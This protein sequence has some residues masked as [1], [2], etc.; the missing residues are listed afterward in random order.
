MTRAAS[1]Y[2]LNELLV[3]AS[4]IGIT[5]SVALPNLAG[6][7]QEARL[8]AAARSFKDEFMRARSIAAR[9]NTQTAIRFETDAT[10]DTSYSTYIDGNFNG[11]LTTDINRGLDRR[12]AGPFRLDAAEDGVEVGVIPGTTSPDGGPLGSEPIRF[13]ST[14]MISFSPL[15]T[16]TQPRTS[17]SSRLVAIRPEGRTD[18]NSESATRLMRPSRVTIVQ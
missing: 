15:V 17:P 12:I 4:I 18:S 3:V 11:V 2:T 13:G 14:K 9:G 6:H 8:T 1:G 5:A 7:R 16:R 10:G